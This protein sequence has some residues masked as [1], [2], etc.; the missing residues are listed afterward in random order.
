MPKEITMQK[1]SI[2]DYGMGNLKSVQK[3][4]EK[5]GAVPLVINTPDKIF[6]SDKVILPGVGAF[7]DCI[8]SLKKYNFDS[9]ILDFVK[10]GK[11]ILG[12]CLGMH[13]MFEKSFEFGEYE[14]LGII[15]GEV[16]KFDNIG[17]LPIPH[18]GWNSIKIEKQ[19]KLLNNI[20]DGSFFYFAHSYY[21]KPEHNKDIMTL[22]EYGITFT[23]S[24]NKD[25]IFGVQFHPEK[26]QE[27]GL[28]IL[29]NFIK[30]L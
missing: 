8:S 10:T 24:V 19:T 4:V 21:V 2:I 28:E 15:K 9:A 12:I 6:E 26:S 16:V 11:Y 30:E 25:N 18:M 22:T 27:K 14:G 1:I 13:V 17:K 3:A 7:R 5:A 20:D 29:K 23:S